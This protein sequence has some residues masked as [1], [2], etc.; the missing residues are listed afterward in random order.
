[1]SKF[2]PDCILRP[3]RRVPATQETKPGLQLLIQS[4]GLAIGLWVKPRREADGDA[5]EAAKFCPKS[6]SKL[7]AMVG[8]HVTGEAMQTENMLDN[9]L[10]SFFR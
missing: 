6:G 8:D 7:G 1:M 3:G 4:L 10:S 5:Q 9:E 2:H